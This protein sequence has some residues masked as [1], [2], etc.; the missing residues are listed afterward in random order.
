MEE[1]LSSVSVLLTVEEPLCQLL[2][3]R[4]TQDAAC[5][6]TSLRRCD[7]EG[8][9][10]LDVCRKRVRARVFSQ[11]ACAR[12]CVC[13]YLHDPSL[14]KDKHGRGGTADNKRTQTEI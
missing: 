11:P 5:W 10:F 3:D 8:P 9:L 14:Q 7:S 6:R 13:P 4:F 2:P 12:V 1:T